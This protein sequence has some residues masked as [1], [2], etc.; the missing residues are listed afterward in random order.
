M[1]SYNESNLCPACL[2][3]GKLK[4]PEK[5][6]DK[7]F[8]ELTFASRKRPELMHYAL[9]EC[10]K[11]KSLFTNRDVN[12]EELLGNYENA[13][14]DSNL[15]AKYAARTYVK[16]LKRALPGFK[17]SVLD[18]GAGDGAFLA[19]ARKEI[20][21]SNLGI[22]PS[23]KAIEKKDDNLVNILNVAIEDFRSNQLFDLVTCFQT[24]EHLNNPRQ[25]ISNMKSF[26]KPGGY[27]A[28][29]CHNRLS[30]VNKLLGEKSP[31]FD[32]EHLQIFTNKG[33]ESL[34]RGLELEIIYS[35][36]YRNEYP[37]SYW[38]KIAPLGEKVKDYVE[39][40]K[41]KFSKD[42][43]IN[44]GNHLIIGRVANN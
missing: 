10:D 43:A 16:Y 20:A 34:F 27:I 18:I 25:F 38:L 22:E 8:N 42:I 7:L 14:Y 3:S 37:L 1:N 32:V 28:I 44:V 11:C 39:S 35:N 36:K 17:G 12:L 41:S 9:F 19:E 24:I 33:I 26:I 6:E 40:H 15:E 30:F 4:Y 23:V 29:S 31:I 2:T 5:I 13:E 21:T